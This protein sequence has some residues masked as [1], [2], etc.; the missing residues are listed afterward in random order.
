MSVKQY[1][2]VAILTASM[3]W[4][5]PPMQVLGYVGVYLIITDWVEERVK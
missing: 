1:I 3:V 4:I 5:C 2:G